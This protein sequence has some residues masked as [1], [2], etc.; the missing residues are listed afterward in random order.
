M[1]L[2]AEEGAYMLIIDSK[3]PMASITFSSKQNIDILEVKDGLAK[4]NRL[5]PQEP[6]AASLAY[7]TL[8][9]ND[10]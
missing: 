5:P 1:N 7:L 4:I 2:I 3:L 9:G 10:M 8:E 6:H